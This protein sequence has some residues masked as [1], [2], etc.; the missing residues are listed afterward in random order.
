MA[1]KGREWIEMG[2]QRKPSTISISPHIIAKKARHNNTPLLIP[3][4]I[5]LGQ[6][7]LWFW[8]G[9]LPE[10]VMVKPGRVR[11]RGV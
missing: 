6:F 9:C 7:G 4:A 2:K 11:S 5:A 10:T 1:E 8:A 3:S